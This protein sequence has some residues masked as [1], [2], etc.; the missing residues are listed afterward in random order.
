ME[1][2]QFE[3]T[4]QAADDGKTNVITLTAITTQTGETY[5]LPIQYQHIGHHTELMGTANY[6]KVK[7]TLQKRH[8]QR[9]I[10]ITLT[11]ALRKVYVDEDGNIIFKDFFLEDISTGTKQGAETGITESV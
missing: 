6:K 10:W 1:K 8:Q 4:V 2:L 3:F 7:T 9:K 5:G 11:E